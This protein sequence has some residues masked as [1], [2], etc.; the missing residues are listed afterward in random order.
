MRMRMA[1]RREY[2]R[3]AFARQLLN[4]QQKADQLPNRG[5]AV[6]AHS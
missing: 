5:C 2:A 4:G 3:L 6:Q 1:S